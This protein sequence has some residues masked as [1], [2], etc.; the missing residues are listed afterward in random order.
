MTYRLTLALD[1]GYSILFDLE[2]IMKIEK[3]S[4]LSFFTL[5]I[6]II[7]IIIFEKC[8][9]ERAVAPMAQSKYQR[10]ETLGDILKIHLGINTPGFKPEL[11]VPIIIL[12]DLNPIVPDNPEYSKTVIALLPVLDSWRLGDSRNVIQ[13]INNSNIQDDFALRFLMDAY[14]KL[15]SS[16]KAVEFGMKIKKKDNLI[17][18]ALGI[19]ALRAQ[20]FDEAIIYFET[21]KTDSI[22]KRFAYEQTGNAYFMKADSYRSYSALKLRNNFLNKAIENWQNVENFKDLFPRVQYS[23]GVANYLI[24]DYDNAREYFYEIYNKREDELLARLF[25]LLS[26]QNQ[27]DEK[28]PELE[29]FLN[30]MLRMSKKDTGEAQNLFKTVILSWY[31]LGEDQFENQNYKRAREYWLKAQTALDAYKFPG[32]EKFE[33][34]YIR[35]IISQMIKEMGFNIDPDSNPVNLFTF[36]ELFDSLRIQSEWKPELEQFASRTGNILYILNEKKLA[37]N[38]YNLVRNPDIIIFNNIL[39]INPKK[40]HSISIED[41]LKMDTNHYNFFVI[42]SIYSSI[43]A[44]EHN[45]DEAPKVL[46]KLIEMKKVVDDKNICNILL[47][48]FCDFLRNSSEHYYHKK[49]QLFEMEKSKLILDNKNYNNIDFQ[50]NRIYDNKDKLSRKIIQ[51]LSILPD[52]TIENSVIP[53]YIFVSENTIEKVNNII[54]FPEMKLL[55]DS[56]NQ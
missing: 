41:L 53:N 47:L 37:Y 54:I 1:S 4:T 9:D 30:N 7:S 13:K 32:K 14:M 56:L 22:W 2:K 23:L 21:L 43:L 15:D 5:V 49:I 51:I 45:Y 38:F 19:C 34:L 55:T 16:K 52:I 26:Y 39:A 10:I 50:L 18:G 40:N 3:I 44:K 46:D 29:N 11:P 20:L 48:K 36:K 25:T 42:L 8:S 6:L 17:N 28:A 31:F 35:A 24:G 27:L 33:F 12:E